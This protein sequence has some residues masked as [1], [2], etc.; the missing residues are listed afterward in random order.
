M[1][2]A[3]AMPM[4]RKPAPSGERHSEQGEFLTVKSHGAAGKS[5]GRKSPRARLGHLGPPGWVEQGR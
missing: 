5:L 4:G 3:F 2:L 1:G